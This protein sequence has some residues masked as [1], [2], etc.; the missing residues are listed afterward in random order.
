[1]SRPQRKW[2]R[3]CIESVEPE[4]DGGRFPAKRVRGD[5]VAVE[6]DVFAD[7]HDL[8][9]A[10]V[11][12]K[13]SGSEG[14]IETP[15]T[16]LVND[17]W[18]GEF[19]AG[20]LGLYQFTIEAWVDVFGTWRRD[21]KKRADAGQ[22]L[23]SEMQAGA[24]LLEKAA[25]AA[26]PEAR[27]L[28]ET[29]ARL[30]QKP[31][32]PSVYKEAM[33]PYLADLMSRFQTKSS[34]LRYGRELEVSVDP[35]LARCG[36][37]Y[38]FFPRSCGPDG[39]HGSFRDCAAR[40][41]Y[42]ASMGFDVVYLPPI[43]PIGSTHRKGRNNSTS[44]RLGDPG[45]PWAIGSP[46]GGHDAIHPLLGTMKDFQEFLA[47]AESLGLSSALDIALQ[48]SPDHPYVHEHP[49]WFRKRPDGSIR[50]A[51][52][53]PKKYEDIYPLDLECPQWEALWKELLRVFLFW[54]KH[55]VRIFRVDNPHTKP[56]AFWEWLIAEVKKE[57]PDA[58]FLSE[59]F[60][61]PKVMHRLAKLGFSQSYTYFAWRTAKWE[62]EQYM[63][64]LTRGPARDFFRPSFWPNTP[65]I[66]NEY[67][68]KGG[69]PAFKTRFVLAATLS[70][71]YGIYGPAFELCA[72]APRQSGSEEYLDSEKYELKRWDL[73]HPDSLRGLI[74][75]VNRARR[76]NPALQSNDGL[77]FHRVDNERLIVYSKRSA[78]GS[79]RVI[80][81]A[82][83]DWA[84]EQA[85]WVEVRL[86]ALGLKPGEAFE[87]DD[88]LGGGT[89]AW[90]GSR[91][92][93]K[94]KPGQAH[95]FVVK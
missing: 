71:N 25:P 22:D 73:N 10:R 58:L 54:A 3:L 27:R 94:L 95:L 18:R 45:S 49:E 63:A 92:F 21:L 74:S 35:P 15:M 88:L 19:P 43:H 80:V 9:G 52:N 76:E 17:R 8:L 7:G 60:T 67:L 82:N 14:F 32:D 91:N 41:E 40:L 68:Q 33:D 6:A 79:N 2:S 55:G 13:K 50:H 31:S 83:L 93:L 11:L 4:I 24:V 47:K 37:W 23:S 29:A 69:P 61:R 66:L 59:A 81:A 1:M 89:Y 26:G 62:I 44:C 42:A 90:R 12:Y 38:E 56:F 51:E 78:E 85:G 34:L 64:E 70:A 84:G 46:E 87:V 86:D 75:A 53:P 36:A 20:E 28:L 77:E 5:V 16:P 65:D 48:C 30:R 39:K 72:N 57:Y